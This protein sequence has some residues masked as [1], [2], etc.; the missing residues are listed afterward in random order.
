MLERQRGL[1]A[2]ERK[3]R[4]QELALEIVEHGIEKYAGNYRVALFTH[5]YQQRD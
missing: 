1:Q 5:L 2:N 3:K 4:H